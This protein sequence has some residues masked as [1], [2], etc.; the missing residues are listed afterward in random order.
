MPKDVSSSFDIPASA[1]NH[2][3]RRAKI[4]PHHFASPQTLAIFRLD[5]P[6][7]D[8]ATIAKE[9]DGP[10]IRRSLSELFGS[11]MLSSESHGEVAS[12]LSAAGDAS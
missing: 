6:R 3:F 5:W 8:I 7:L 1:D 4:T 11:A 9:Q 2:L 10:E 12:V